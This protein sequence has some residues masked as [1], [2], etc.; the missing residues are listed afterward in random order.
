MSHFDIISAQPK[1]WSILSRSFSADR[2]ASTYLFTGPDGAGHWAMAIAL[3][4]LL[5]CEHPTEPDPDKGYPFARPCGT[6]RHCRTVAGLNFEGLHMVVPVPP[7]ENKLDKAIELTGEFLEVLREESLTLQSST[8]TLSLPISMARDVNTKLSRRAGEGI[9]RIA[10]FHRMERMK[11]S[12]ADALLKLIEEPPRDTVI[13]LT[14]VKPENLL[15]TIRSRAQ[16]VRL[17]RSPE[18]MI[19]DYLKDRYGASEKRATLMARLSRGLPGRAVKLAL[20]E[21]E[22]QSNRSLGWLLFKSMFGQSPADTVYLITDQVNP[23]DRGQAED[24]L[25]LWQSLVRDCA[26]YA[27]CGEDD[28]ITN[29]DFGADIAEMSRA[30]RDSSVSERMMVEIKNTLDDFRYNVHIHTALVALALKLSRI[31]RGAGTGATIPSY[32]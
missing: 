10:I 5:N 14:A 13:I 6:C 27:I 23:R 31:V 19:V 16:L 30:F 25:T 7:H 32:G 22:E 29:I 21:E 18:R 24:I 28:D 9:T 3:A 2:I 11:T 12:S 26:H 20:E 1:A 4:S 8:E 15:P 17:G